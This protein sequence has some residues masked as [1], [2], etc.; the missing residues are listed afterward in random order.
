[1]LRHN[2]TAHQTLTI[3][4]HVRDPKINK[5][6]MVKFIQGMRSEGWSAGF[7]GFIRLIGFIGLLGD[8]VVFKLDCCKSI[9]I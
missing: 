3:K 1:M 6:V 7:I 9:F 2:H 5:P 8:G 4:V